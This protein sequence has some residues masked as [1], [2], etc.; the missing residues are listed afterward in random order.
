MS[1]VTVAQ[2]A[3]VLKVPVDKLL[4]QLDEAGI[5]VAGAD[6]RISDEAKTEALV[7][8]APRA[9]PCRG[10]SGDGR[11]AQDHAQ[12]QDAERDQARRPG[13]RPHRQRR[14]AHQA[15]LHQARGARG[16]GAPPAGG[17]RPG[18]ARPRRPRAA[19]SREERSA[20]RPSGGP[21]AHRGGEPQARGG[22][23]QGCRGGGAPPGRGA[24]ARG[25]RA[26]AQGRRSGPGGRGRAAATTSNAYGR[27]ELHVAGD[28]SSRYKKKKSHARPPRR[29]AGGRRPATPSRCRPRRSSAKCRSAEAM[30]VAEL[31]QKMAVK[32]TEVIKVMMNM[33]VMATINQTIDQDTAVLVVEEMGHTAVMRKENVIE[34]D[35]QSETSE[36]ARGRAAPAGG[37]R[38]G[39]RRPRQ[40]LAA[41]LHPQAPRSRRAR[42]AASPS[43]SARIRSRPRQRRWSR[44]STRPATRR[45]PPCAPAAPRSP[46][47]SS[48]WSRPTTA[49]CRRPSRRSSTRR[50]PRCRSWWRSTRSTSRRPNPERVK[51]ELT[52]HGVVPEE[53]GG[54]N[55]FV[56]GFG[57]D[58]PGR[59]S[60]AGDAAAAGRGARAQGADR[61]ARRRA[62]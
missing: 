36:G 29:R 55:I 34:E 60:A 57:A 14:G 1:D 50:R 31:A 12:A 26:P 24:R 42:P 37:D 30:T 51:Q 46:T 39:P 19:P 18:S 23:P 35:L 40:D 2:F 25:S 8:P 58:R 10:G 21:R 53:W 45:S 47:S 54:E 4:K 49:S 27:Q 20:R 5:R 56:T 41:R 38:H 32:A 52:K 11:P 61:R 62:T 3:E 43:T 22:R 9:R 28:V 7:A 17:G 15:H 6:D 48:S 16:A 44:S 59:R 33:G 13:P